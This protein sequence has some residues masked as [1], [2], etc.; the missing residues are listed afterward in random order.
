MLSENTFLEHNVPGDSGGNVNIL[1]GD[2]IGHC[3]ENVDVYR[4]RAVWI[5][6]VDLLTYSM[7]QSPS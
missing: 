4:E 6:R 2:S 5:S 1:G 3:E 7:E